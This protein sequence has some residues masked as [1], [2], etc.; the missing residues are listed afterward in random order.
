M[1]HI[2]H[3][4][5]ADLAEGR[6]APEEAAALRARVEADPEARAQLAA[7]ERLIGLMR[8]DAGV[9]APDHVIARAVR[10]M[11]RPSAPPAPGLLQR[12]VAILR[13]DSRGQ[14]LAAGVRTSSTTLRS[15]SYGAGEWVIDLQLTPR[16]GRW[17]LRGQLIG[18]EVTGSVVLSGA[19]E[20]H[21][22]PLDELGEF[23]M[24]A[25]PAGTYTLLIRVDS[26][27]IVVE[28]LELEP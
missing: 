2:S 10:L 8:S 12:L 17:Q 6:L 22:A 19:G 1:P 5:L 11:R 13:S 26:R 14:P 4:Q 24:P 7:L 23:S 3:E 25:V 18:P 21:S 15:L 16:A 28:Q 20:P 27:E 9:D